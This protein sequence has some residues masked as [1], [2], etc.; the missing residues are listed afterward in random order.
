[1]GNL[2]NCWAKSL[3]I[4]SECW[5]HVTVFVCQS[6][7][8]GIEHMGKRKTLKGHQVFFLVIFKGSCLQLLVFTNKGG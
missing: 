5:K 3:E 6:S 8:Q 4:F 2:Y 1:M 7:D